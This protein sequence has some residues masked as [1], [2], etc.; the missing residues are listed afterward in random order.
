MI[1]VLLFGA[2]GQLGQEIVARAAEFGVRIVPRARQETDIAD[3]AMVRQCLDAFAPDIVVNAAAY[4]KVD[5][6][7]QD[8]EEAFRVN[9]AA[10]GVLAQ[11]CSAA[12][13]PLIHFSTDYVFDGTKQSAYREDDPIAPL[14]VYGASKAAG[15]DAIRS[16]CARHLI[17]R[18]SWVFGRYG[19]NFV[20]TVL[21]LAGERE[22]ISIVADQRGC[23]TATADLAEAVFVVAP[24]LVKGDAPWGTY[25]F[26]GDGVTTWYGFAQ[27]IVDQQALLTGRG[28]KVVPITSAD[29]P[30]R[31]RRPAN[32]QLDSSKFEATFQFQAKPWQQ[33]VH[34]VV[35]SLIVGGGAGTRLQPSL[36]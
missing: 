35:G 24:R 28:P 31:A 26:A 10:P 15:E 11:A 32:S 5:Q 20:K 30:T 6:A 25:H 18:T 27:E 16:G 14:G 17:L 12:G 3:A 7:E 21:K 13:V 22:S 19:W 4:T 36:R 1:T 9:A 33:R 29:Y 23:P 34:D 2:G 8:V